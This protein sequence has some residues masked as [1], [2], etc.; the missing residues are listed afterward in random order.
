M[1]A[2]NDNTPELKPCP[3]CG[4]ETICMDEVDRHLPFN[5]YCFDCSA[6]GPMASTKKEAIAWWNTR[7]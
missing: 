3:F 6:D 2:K 5:A 7:A 1:T 4:S